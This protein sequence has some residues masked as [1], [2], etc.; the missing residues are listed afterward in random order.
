M[1][2]VLPARLPP[3]SAPDS[4]LLL[5]NVIARIGSFGRHP[6]ALPYLRFASAGDHGED[7]Q[8]PTQLWTPFHPVDYLCALRCHCGKVDLKV[9]RL[10]L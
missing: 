6:L 5:S 10:A 2:A 7:A 4:H 3:R 9:G 8:R 1:G